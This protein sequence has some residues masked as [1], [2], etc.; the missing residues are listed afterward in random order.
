[1]IRIL[2]LCCQTTMHTWDMTQ[3][4]PERESCQKT[5]LNFDTATHCNT[6]QQS[7][8]HC[9]S[10]TRGG[11]GGSRREC[12]GRGKRRGEERPISHVWM[13]HVTYESVMSHMNAPCR[14]WMR[15]GQ[16]HGVTGVTAHCN[17]LQQTLV[18]I[19]THCSTLLHTL[20]L[21]WLWM[22][23]LLAGVIWLMHIWHDSSIRNMTHS[24]VCCFFQHVFSRGD[25]TRSYVTWLIH[26]WHDSFI[27]DMTHSST[28]CCFQQRW[29]GSCIRDMNHS[30]VIWLIY[31]W[32]HSFI[33]GY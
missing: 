29:H 16:G 12:A 27:C 20:W 24:S 30:H 3:K 1:M 8:I 23:L 32:H 25:M 4:W 26:M 18:H 17:I 21:A 10:L 15:R 14:I 2:D 22:L 33:R 11:N 6:L 31:M 5:C 7:A 19:A 28:C 13:S 9:N